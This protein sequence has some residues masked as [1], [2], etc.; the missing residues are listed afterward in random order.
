M[1]DVTDVVQINITG[2]TAT[3]LPLT[4]PRFTMRFNEDVIQRLTKAF[5]DAGQ[6]PDVRAVVLRS[7]GDSFCAG[8][9]LH[10]MKA[11][12]NYTYEENVTDAGQVATLL[13]TIR[14]CPKAHCGS[15]SW[16]YVWWW[17][18]LNCGL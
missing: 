11:M 3:H 4:G 6:N 17:T 12:V 13:Q 7:E 14:T 10:W 9:D 16:G 18:W 1:T 5:E 8:A 15:G 2:F